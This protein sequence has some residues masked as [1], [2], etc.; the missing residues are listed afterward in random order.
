[1]PEEPI[2]PEYEDDDIPFQLPKANNFYDGDL[3]SDSELRAQDVEEERAAPSKAEPTV[4]LP[5]VLKDD[6]DEIPEDVL[7]RARTAMHNVPQDGDDEDIPVRSAARRRSS[8]DS[9]RARHLQFSTDQT[10][11]P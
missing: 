11:Q 4:D 6:T 9:G 10:R 5:E 3:L 2:T 8:T 7:K 1:M